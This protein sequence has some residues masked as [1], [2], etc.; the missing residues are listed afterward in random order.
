MSQQHVV[1]IVVL[2]E[3]NCVLPTRIFLPGW[4]THIFMKIQAVCVKQ[5]GKVP[6]STVWKLLIPFVY[7][8]D[9]FFFSVYYCFCIVSIDVGRQIKDLKAA[10]H[11]RGSKTV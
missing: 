1:C 2:I 9:D 6:V 11:V 4:V 8:V 5:C 7:C 3:I 10:Y